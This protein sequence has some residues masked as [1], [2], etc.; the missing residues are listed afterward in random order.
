MGAAKG[1]AKPA[2][3]PV[4]T[5]PAKGAAKPAAAKQA[6]ISNALPVHS[7]AL[8]SAGEPQTSI[9]GAREHVHDQTPGTAHTFQ[10]EHD[11]MPFKIID[12]RTHHSMATVDPLQDGQE[13]EQS[14]NTDTE[15]SRSP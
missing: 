2:V 8:N 13:A 4:A 7:V 15:R 14:G 9:F 12:L 6:G 5:V 11:N 1:P 3:K 10:S